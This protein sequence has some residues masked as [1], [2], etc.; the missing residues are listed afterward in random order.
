MI[1]YPL[2]TIFMHPTIKIERKMCFS[3]SG[4]VIAPMVAMDPP[5]AQAQ[6]NGYISFT[7]KNNGR[8]IAQLQ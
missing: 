3:I 8:L 6:A 2:R 7:E 4:V 1:I 5:L